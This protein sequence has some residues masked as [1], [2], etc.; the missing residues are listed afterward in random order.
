M[1]VTG[2]PLTA[3]ALMDVDGGSVV[4]DLTEAAAAT[5]AAGDYLPFLDG[6]TTGTQSKGSINDVATLFAGTASATGL[7]ASSGVL[8]V[9]DLTALGVSGS[10]NQMLTD[11]GDGTVTSEANLLFDGTGLKIKE[12]S[13]AA[14]DTAAY[15]QIWV[16]SDTP[17]T[18]YYTD[19]AGTDTQ[20]GT[21]GGFT[22]GQIDGLALSWVDVSTVQIG[23]GLA[24]DSAD[25]ANIEL[26]GT[27]NVDITASGINGLDTGSEATSTWYSVWVVAGASGT[28]GLLSTSATSPTLPAGYDVSK[29][30][31]GWIYNHSDNDIQ[32]FIQTGTGRDRTNWWNE[33][34]AN[35]MKILDS[36]NGTSWSVVDA[37]NRVPTT[38]SQL[39]LWAYSAGGS[40]NGVWIRPIDFLPLD[41]GTH[42]WAVVAQSQSRYQNVWMPCPGNKEVRY[43]CEHSSCSTYLIVLGWME[44]L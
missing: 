6:G 36:G 31:I 20:L 9:T 5:I 10:A 29:R 43:K 24:R 34:G 25:A 11:D 18:L 32:A 40:A 22:Q 12:Q 33:T 13:A 39:N 38:A 17:N 4:V 30:R 26:T 23:I 19:D 37:A 41:T 27:Q 42:G 3:G 7:S 44:T 16:K 15:G 35:Y 8:S 21:G 14:A 28:G 1:K 2:P